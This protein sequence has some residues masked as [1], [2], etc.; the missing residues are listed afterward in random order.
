[1]AQPGMAQPGKE[2][3]VKAIAHRVYLNRQ[4]RQR[5]GDAYSDWQIAEALAQNPIKRILFWSHSGLLALRKLGYRST[6][7][8]VWDIPKWGIF[9]LPKLEWVKLLAVPLVIAAA[10]SII[11]RNFQ[12]EAEQNRILKEYFA[13]LET[14][15]FEQGLLDEPLDS[16]VVLLARGRTVATLR[17]LDLLR[18]EQLIAF[19]R[20]SNLA[21]IY[22]NRDF[23]DFQEPVISFKYQDLSEIDL[24][25]VS[26]GSL[27]FRGTSFQAA[28]LQASIFNN[29]NFQDAFFE[30]A[31]LQNADLSEANLQGAD[32]READLQKAFLWRANLQNAFLREAN[33]QDVFLQEASLQKAYLREAN[34]QNATLSEANLQNA[35]L[36]L[37]NLQGASLAN[38]NLRD[39]DLGFADL[40]NAFIWEADLQDAS[41]VNANLQNAVLVNANLQGTDLRFANLQGLSLAFAVGGGT[42]MLETS[43]SKIE[44]Q[45]LEAKL[46]RTVLPEYIELDGNRDCDSP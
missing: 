23:G 32:L 15:T 12:R 25:T 41:L 18:R 10:G 30:D 40:R 3:R 46:C 31:N 13:L 6:K 26:L 28:N 36:Q 14:F 35:H 34:L 11:T 29:A 42:V 37:V 44:E 27:D 9:S 24:R 20:A 38:A 16:G 22:P 39:A 8:V 45:L 33:L 2:D 19:L 17:E 4:L 7:F 1:M 5:S 43:P 21:V